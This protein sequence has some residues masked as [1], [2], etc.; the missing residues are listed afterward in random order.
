MSDEVPVEKNTRLGWDQREIKFCLR[1]VALGKQH[2]F[3]G[4]Q[5]YDGKIGWASSVAQSLLVLR[6]PWT[7]SK[8][9]PQ[10]YYL[11]YL[12]KALENTGLLTAQHP[13]SETMAHDIMILGI[14]DFIG[15]DLMRSSVCHT[16]CFGIP[17]PMY[18]LSSLIN[19][20]NSFSKLQSKY[21]SLWWASHWPC[22]Q[23]FLAKGQGCMFGKSW[24]F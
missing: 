14:W 5:F 19:K 6:M 22:A 1:W 15:G 20:R 13:G 23:E 4:P 3:S 11:C 18:P 16:T 2:P 9:V 7:E 8:N 24:S 12:R 21:L 10:T 17:S